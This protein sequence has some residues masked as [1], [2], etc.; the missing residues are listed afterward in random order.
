MS[1]RYVW[2]R[3]VLLC[4]SSI[5]RYT[6]YLFWCLLLVHIVVAV[7]GPGG[8]GGVFIAT[9]ALVITHFA[10]CRHH[11]DDGAVSRDSADAGGDSQVHKDGTNVL[12]PS[13]HWYALT[14]AGL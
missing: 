8:G 3:E 9:Y 7:R 12:S 2:N 5:S 14:Q 4:S 6:P 13:L 1:L 11:T 10:S